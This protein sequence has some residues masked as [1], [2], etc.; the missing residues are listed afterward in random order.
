[1]AQCAV[2]VIS[3]PGRSVSSGTLKGAGLGDAA[4]RDFYAREA[5]SILREA[6]LWQSLQ[7]EATIHKIM[8][9]RKLDL[10]QVQEAGGEVPD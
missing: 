6:S 7:S 10:A 8:E 3:V 1:M 2:Q 4:V 5:E 9:V